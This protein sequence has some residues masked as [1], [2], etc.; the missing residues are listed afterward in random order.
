MRD[1]CLTL[2]NHE[3]IVRVVYG[4][5]ALSRPISQSTGTIG[6][7]RCTLDTNPEQG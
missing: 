4:L 6:G 7:L 5:C 1:H 2:G 3:I